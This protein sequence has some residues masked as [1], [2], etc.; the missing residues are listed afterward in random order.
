ML[1][2]I[3]NASKT[4]V[5]RVLMAAVM[6][7]LAGIFGLWGIN[8]IFHGFGRS[9]VAEI[10]GTD[11]GIQQFQQAYNDQLQKLGQQL[12]RPITPEQ[13][14]AYGVPRQVLS[15]MIAQAG[16]DER[17][18]RMRLAMSDNEI[19]RRI[20]SNPQFQTPQ[21]QF[22]RERFQDALQSAGFTEQRFVAE[23]RG[24]MLRQQIIDSIS[25]DIAVPKTW[26]EAVDQF[27]RQQRSVD[28]VELG[29][30]QAGDIPQPT[31]E[32]LSKY[33]DERKIM[34]RAPEYRK[35]VTVT[36]TPE[37]LAKSAEVSD[38]AVK[39]IFDQYRNRYI[40]PE[41]RHVEQM[42]FPTMAEAEAASAQIKAGKS[43]AQLA[44]ER[45]LKEQDLDLGMVTKSTI[46]DPAVADAAFALQDGEVSAPIQGRFG[47]VLVT[48]TQI[49]SEENKTFADV[50]PQ[51][52]SEIAVAQA[53]KIV[54]DIHDKVE[55][56]R[57]G[58]ATLEEAAQKLNLPVTTYDALDRSGR[59]PSGNPAANLPDAG[60]VVNAAFTTDVGVDNDPIE[61][62]GG[63]IW[64]DVTA[65]TPAH[66]RTL[67]EVK[68]EV[69]AR[70]R[71]DQIAARVKAKAADMLDKLK[72]GSPLDTVAAAEGAKVEHA[73]A[74]KRGQS[75]PVISNRAIEAIFHTAQGGFG[76]AEAD[77]P[78][79][80]IVFR[81]SDVKTPPLDPNSPDAKRLDQTLQRQIS[82][83]VFGQYMAWLENDL[84]TTVN[85]D[86]LAQAL[87]NGA[88]DT[89]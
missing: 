74:I 7:L 34:F 45:G 55:D 51:I 83:D 86:V 81:V 53:K 22:D 58:G 10:G 84:G 24:V 14:N 65:I 61:S 4:R 71:D 67:D 46:I 60:Q 11:I 12:G 28:Y 8:D 56:A 1:R 21:G 68:N 49:E 70:W 75:L 17:A 33:F 5:G 89:N 35:I 64:Y 23:Q 2:G 27:Q 82:D 76:S 66:D 59:D 16:L 80:W 47:A 48:V 69:E 26:L 32:E 3:R 20:T 62:N 6:T 15:E 63:Y 52:R 9:T 42:V 13:A 38:D 85:A 87:G 40:T 39:Q 72:S 54:Q 88:P 77:N 44:A 57:A 37:Q 50:A 78:T 25:G 30:A 43:F 79:Q 19:A 29:A 36:A 31:D 18:H 41:R 73:D